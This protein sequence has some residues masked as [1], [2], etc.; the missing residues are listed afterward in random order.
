MKVKEVYLR[1]IGIPILALIMVA[2]MGRAPQQ[3]IWEKFLQSLVFTAVYWNGAFAIFMYFRRK[4]PEIRE[5]PKRILFTLTAL[6]L[7]LIVGDIIICLALGTKQFSDLNNLAYFFDKTPKSIMAALVVGSVYENVYFFQ[8]WKTTI[9]ANEALKSQQIRTQFEVLQNQMSP[10]FLFN[11]LNTLNSLIVEDPKVAIE[12]NEKLSDVYRYILQNKERELVS[13]EEEIKFVE[14][15]LFL[16]KMRYPRNLKVEI[17]IDPKYYIFFLPPLTIQ[18]LVENSIKHN[19]VSTALPLVIE[20][21]VEKNHSLMVKN[22][23][24]PK[25]S[26]E[27]STKTGLNNIKKRYQYLSEKNIEVITTTQ[28]FLVAVPLLEVF[29]SDKLTLSPS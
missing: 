17:N 10:H 25:K 11:S 3:S 24:Q 6:L 1:W 22:N 7:L 28:N 5:T 21:Y 19:V 16:L 29:S 20:I 12:F 27:K 14:D 8:K 15:Y 26:L 23:L 18:M 9:Q 4:F 13:L 2:I